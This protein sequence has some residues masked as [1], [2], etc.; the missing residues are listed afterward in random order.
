MTTRCPICGGEDHEIIWPAH[1]PENLTA[2]EF[3]YTGS[4]RHHGRVVQCSGCGHRFVS[5]VPQALTGYYADVTDPFYVSTEQARVRTFEEFLDRKEHYCPARGS[6]LDVGCYAG[7]FLDVAAR[8]GYSVEG[9][10]LST[11]ARDIARGRGHRV[12]AGPV[13]RLA[14]MPQRYDAVTAFDVLE[15]LED[16]AGAARLIRDRLTPSGCFIATVPDT[17]AWHARL[18]GR[19]HWL[20][21]TMH[22]QYFTHRTLHRLLSSA[23]FGNVRIATAP[24]YRLRIADAAAYSNASPLLRVPFALL[25]RAPGVNHLELRLKASLFA[26]AQR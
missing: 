14:S 8:R 19:R 11:W 25:K 6:L 17:G 24:P 4:K 7:V 3:S 20:I 9:L 12:H 1:L 15:H 22:V 5:P 2:A 16:P 26:V 10:E 18:L 21:V 23:G 13:D